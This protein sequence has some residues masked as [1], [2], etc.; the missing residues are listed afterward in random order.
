MKLRLLFF[1]IL[2]LCL[3]NTVGYFPVFKLAQRQIYND[4]EALIEQSFSNDHLHLISISSENQHALHWQRAGKEFWYN[5]QLYDIVRLEKKDG[6]THYYCI[7][8]T[9]ETRLAY[10]YIE[11]LKT[12]TDGT[13]GENTPLSNFFKKELKIYFPTPC[14][15]ETLMVSVPVFSEK[16]T[17]PSYSNLYESMFY[18]RIDAPPKR[19]I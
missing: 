16:T 18:N 5:G 15:Q 6:I 13:D 12:Q 1:S 7:K 3:L 19:L 14:R 11:Y 2:A 10:Q 17:M 8:D 4:I 9:A